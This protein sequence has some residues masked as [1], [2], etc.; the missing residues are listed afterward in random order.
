MLDISRVERGGCRCKLKQSLGGEW[1]KEGRVKEEGEKKLAWKMGWINNGWNGKG[2]SGRDRWEVRGG[3]IKG[4]HLL[5]WDEGERSRAEG[6]R[7]RVVGE[8]VRGQLR[9]AVRGA[10]KI[11]EGTRREVGNRSLV[12]QDSQQQI[13]SYQTTV[14]FCF[15]SP[16]FSHPIVH[17]L[18]QHFFS[19]FTFD[20]E[21]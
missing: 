20:H 10:G 9:R 19:Y 21:N 11:S 18:L 4:L 2:R 16:S 12:L 7:S 17:F 14:H 6:R 15:P 13:I 1:G 3:N 5:F 8:E